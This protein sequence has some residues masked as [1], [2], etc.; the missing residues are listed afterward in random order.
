M[1]ILNIFSRE[2]A[3]TVHHRYA[4][5]L[6]HGPCDDNQNQRHV[7]SLWP[8]WNMLDLMPQGRGQDGYPQLSYRD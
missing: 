4:S 6:L 1:P 8:L 7:D 2:D 5:E 3:G